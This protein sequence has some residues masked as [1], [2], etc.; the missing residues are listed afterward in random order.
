[1]KKVFYKMSSGWWIRFLEQQPE[2][3]LRRGDATAHVRMD[4][5]NSET[6]KQLLS[7]MM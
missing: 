5:V 7:L 6:M 4:A 1:V 3:S 2:L